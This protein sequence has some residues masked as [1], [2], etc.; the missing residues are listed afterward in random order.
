MDKTF[1]DTKGAFYDAPRCEIL[2]LHAEGVICGSGFGSPG[3]A[4]DMFNNN[5]YGSF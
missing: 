5:D 2:D 1:T 3:A 4:G